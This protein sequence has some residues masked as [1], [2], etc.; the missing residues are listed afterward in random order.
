MN[1]FNSTETLTNTYS[2]L[3]AQTKFRLDQIN[4]IKD[5]FNSEI[6]RRRIMSKKLSKYIAAFDNFDKSL[7]V[8]STA[9][10]R[11]SVITLTGIITIPV[12]IANASVSLVFSLT[13]G[14]IKKM[15]TITRNKKKKHNK[16]AMLAKSNLNSIET[17]ISQAL[18]DLEI[19]HEEYKTIVNEKEGYDRIKESIRNIKGNDKKD[20]LSENNKNIR[21]K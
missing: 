12:G 17:L 20:G 4:K 8:L 21:K 19:I 6:Q 9:S 10:G 16:T 14:I 15:L 18:I 5:Y 1:E 11:I 7:I 13:T 3:N 2:N